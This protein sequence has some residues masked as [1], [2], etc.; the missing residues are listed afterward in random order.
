MSGQNSP[1]LNPL[2]YR[3][4]GQCRSLESYRKEG[5]AEAK[6]KDARHQSCSGLPEKAT[7]NVMK[8]FCKRLQALCQPMVV[9]LSVKCD[10]SD[11]KY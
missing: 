3:M 2:D 8:D 1:A 4:R 7:N 9:I 11:N 10:N 5:A 6:F